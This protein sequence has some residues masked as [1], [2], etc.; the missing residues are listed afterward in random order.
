MDSFSDDLKADSGEM[1][2]E[3]DTKSEASHKMMSFKRKQYT[4]NI[5][6]MFLAIVFCMLFCTS[7]VV[8]TQGP[9]TGKQIPPLSVDD[10]QHPANEP[11]SSSSKQMEA[12][13]PV[14]DL[15]ANMLAVQGL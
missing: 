12:K 14:P 6:Y 15:R 5:G 2:T 4:N 3:E 13:P 10:L 9:S 11:G 1:Q 7:L 8:K